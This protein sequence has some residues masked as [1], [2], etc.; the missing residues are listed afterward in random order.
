MPQ[1]DYIITGG[2]AS[3]LS[4]VYHLLQSSLRDRRILIIDKVAKYQNDRTWCFWEAEPGPFDQI[5][6]KQ[7]QDLSFFTDQ[8]QQQD[9]IAPYTYK[10]IRG[11]DF[12]QFMDKVIDGAPN[13]ERIQGAVAAIR[14]EGDQVIVTANGQ[15]YR[16]PWCFNSILFQPIEKEGSNYLDQHFK[17]WVINTKEPQFDPDKATLMDFRLPQM[18]ETRFFYVLPFDQHRALVELAIFSNDL[19][20]QKAYDEAIEQYLQTHLNIY[21]PDFDVEETEFGVIPMT[22]YAFRQKE[23]RIIHIGTAGGH[24]KASTGYTFWRMQKRLQKMVRALEVGE[25][26]KVSPYASFSRFQLYD[27]VLLHILERD[28]LPADSLFGTLFSKNKMSDVLKFLNE[29]TT[30]FGELKIMKVLPILTFSRVM[31]QEIARKWSFLKKK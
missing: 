27:S 11:I 19:W 5:V 24:T 9:Y 14:N 21:R 23:G 10:M 30:F 20:T 2:G 29:D 3:G 25:V 7:W 4:L 22:D 18:G 12:Y 17:G 15:E 31:L 28:L 13:V 6:Y 1:Y 26:P 16:A 8:V